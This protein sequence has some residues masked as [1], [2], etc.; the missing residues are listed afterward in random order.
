MKMQVFNAKKVPSKSSNDDNLPL[1]S[2]RL[3]HTVLL[4]VES[5]NDS[6]CAAVFKFLS[7]YQLIKRSSYFRPSKT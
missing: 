6:F 2:S 7:D 4:T 1:P 3:H 5:Q